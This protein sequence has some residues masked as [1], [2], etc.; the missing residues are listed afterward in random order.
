MDPAE[1]GL[2][3]EIK[4][5]HRGRGLRTPGLEVGPAVRNTLRLSDDDTD[6]EL[7]RRSLIV[8]WRRCADAMPRDL[9]ALLLV[10]SAI[11]YGHPDLTGRLTHWAQQQGVGIRSAWRHYSDTVD[12]LARRLERGSGG[13]LGTVDD[14]G[15]YVIEFSQIADLST[16]SPVFTAHRTIR[17]TAPVLERDRRHRGVPGAGRGARVPL[18]RGLR[19]DIGRPPL[20]GYLGV[21]PA[22]AATPHQR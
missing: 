15:F 5:L 12:H 7:I 4:R 6:V 16:S 20:R 2:V 19:R 3:A 11:S 18:P 13:D 1:S 10:A 8:A 21:S 9:G 22:T 17:V 14:E